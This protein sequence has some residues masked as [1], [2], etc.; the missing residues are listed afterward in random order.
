MAPWG[1]GL[2]SAG[3]QR[4]Q[5]GRAELGCDPCS[6]HLVQVNKPTA[7][8]HPWQTEPMKQQIRAIPSSLR[9]TNSGRGP[10]RQPAGPSQLTEQLHRQEE[11]APQVRGENW[12]SGQ[13]VSPG[14]LAPPSTKISAGETGD[15]LTYA[16]EESGF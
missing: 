16:E 4:N 13:C 2:E 15:V 7:G 10:S 3:E 11:W 9:P 8:F 5:P 1:L 6:H 12:G 14:F